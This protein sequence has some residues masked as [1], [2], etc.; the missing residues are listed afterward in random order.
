MWVLTTLS[1]PACRGAHLSSTAFGAHPRVT[2][3]RSELPRESIR[4]A[5]IHGRASTQP[6]PHIPCT[7]K[8]HAKKHR[9]VLAHVVSEWNKRLAASLGNADM[10]AQLR[11]NRRGVLAHAVLK[12]NKGLVSSLGDADVWIQLRMSEPVDLYVMRRSDIKARWKWEAS[13]VVGSSQRR[14]QLTRSSPCSE[15]RVTSCYKTRPA[16][17]A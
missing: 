6:P 14:G 3:L 13:P 16:K 2:L 9:T 15:F 8:H 7:P 5:H 1:G 11:V 12:W 4:A 10:W 17:S